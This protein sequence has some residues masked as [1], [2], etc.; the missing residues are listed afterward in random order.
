MQAERGK[1][2]TAELPRC[3]DAAPPTS[4]ASEATAANS[5]PNCPIFDDAHTHPMDQS[6]PEH[7][8]YNLVPSIV[9]Q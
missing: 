7:A 2:R 9:T 8:D 6:Q 1:V 3:R 4:S 5:H